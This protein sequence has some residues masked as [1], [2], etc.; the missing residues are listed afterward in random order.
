[1]SNQEHIVNIYPVYSGVNGLEAIDNYVFDTK[2]EAEDF[3]LEAN[4]WMGT[5][6]KHRAVYCPINVE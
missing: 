6:P 3:V 5:K 1:M 2:E 4:H